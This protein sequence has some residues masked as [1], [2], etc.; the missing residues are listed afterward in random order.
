MS[1]LKILNIIF[2][3]GSIIELNKRV[4]GQSL[5]EKLKTNNELSSTSISTT[6]EINENLDAHNQKER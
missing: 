4:N 6:V 2:F 3:L 1:K 5:D